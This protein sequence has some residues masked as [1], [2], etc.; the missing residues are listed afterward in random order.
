VKPLLSILPV[1]AD[2]AELWH[3]WRQDPFARKYNPFAP[4]PVEALRE[5]LSKAAS[6][7]SLFGQAENFIWLLMEGDQV[8]GNLNL[9][10]INP[11]MLT[12]ELGYMISPESRGKGLATFC[13]RWLTRHCFENTPLRK[14][15]AY[16]HEDNLPSRRVLEKSGYQAEGLLREHYLIEGRPANEVIF[17]ILRR[18]WQD[19]K[20]MQPSSPS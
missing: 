18:D 16:V 12:A 13:V 11:M 17:G 2:H 14:L 5:R 8:V 9:H 7:L 4:S 3:A 15:I 6:D 20:E 10:N 1:D 19:W